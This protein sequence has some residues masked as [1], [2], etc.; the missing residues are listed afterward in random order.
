MTKTCYAYIDG[1]EP[2]TEAALVAAIRRDPAEVWVNGHSARGRRVAGKL[3]RVPPG[4]YNIIGPKDAP[5]W[6]VPIR[7]WYERIAKAHIAI[8]SEGEFL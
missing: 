8:L 2:A 4:T 7:V 3:T 6:N 1:K 5:L